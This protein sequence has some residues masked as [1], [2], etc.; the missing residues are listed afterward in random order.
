MGE[1]V[2]Q[3][4]LLFI[5]VDVVAAEGLL[6]IFPLILN[7]LGLVAILLIQVSSKVA[8]TSEL[9]KLMPLVFSCGI[10]GEN[11]LFRALLAFSFP[12]L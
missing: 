8:I 2:A 4:Q 12:L 3:L 5:S 7:F 11:R 1:G 9:V 10:K 6:P